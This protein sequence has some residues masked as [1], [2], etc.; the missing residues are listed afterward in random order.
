MEKRRM[1]LPLGLLQGLFSLYPLL[2]EAV[3]RLVS[4]HRGFVVMR[5]W[6]RWSGGLCFG[7]CWVG[8]ALL[9]NK[10]SARGY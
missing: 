2:K 10:L 1:K 9:L 4:F 8:R 5:L 3:L 6:L 7:R